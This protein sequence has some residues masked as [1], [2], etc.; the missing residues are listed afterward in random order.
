MGGGTVGLLHPGEMGAAIGR[1]L[2]ERGDTVVWASDA[3]GEATRQRAKSAG[4][5]DA[6]SVGEVARRG[7]T[8][9]S[10]CPPHAAVEVARS[11]SAAGFEGLYVD[12][13][14][15]SPATART[16][17][18]V[19]AEGGGRCVDGGI[20]GGPP[21]RAG[22]TRIYVSGA[23]AGAV[24]ELFAGTALGVAVLDGGIGAAS[25]LKMAYG[26][27]TKGSAALLLAVRAL[28]RGEGVEPAL[29]DEWALSQPAL[30]DRSLT[31]ARS[32]AT[33]GWRWIAEMEEIAA[34]M[35]ANGLPPGFHQA[36]ATIFAS[37]RSADP[38]PDG[39]AVEVVINALLASAP[40]AAARDDRA[41]AGGTGSITAPDRATPATDGG[42][43][44]AAGGGAP[45]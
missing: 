39:P 36:A 43:P 27:W 2:R 18:S 7:E 42:A 24:A 30:P 11:V 8:I 19:I 41:P 10:I 14:A 13:N 17:V 12:A 22:E 6:G 31:A 21:E 15:V 32:A 20:I 44:G 45:G 37:G 3:R 29:L 4:L 26:G 40:A 38:D 5:V 9:L 34:T 16:I 33:K 1:L 23:G 35:A 25:A 28:A